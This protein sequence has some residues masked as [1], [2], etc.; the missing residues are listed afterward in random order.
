MRTVELLEAQK[1]FVEVGLSVPDD[2]NFFG[3]GVGVE[4]AHC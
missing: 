4:L 3:V 2:D 1:S